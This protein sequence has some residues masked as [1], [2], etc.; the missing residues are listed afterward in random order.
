MTFELNAS[1]HQH[2][3]EAE[4]EHARLVREARSGDR[5]LSAVSRARAAVGLG[6][7][8]LGIALGGETARRRAKDAVRPRS[9]AI[10]A[11]RAM[12]R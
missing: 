11:P 7:V 10:R 1:H 9:L 2:E 6:I 8:E 12:P 3:L 5:T 4:A